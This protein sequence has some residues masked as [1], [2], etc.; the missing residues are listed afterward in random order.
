MTIAAEWAFKRIVRHIFHYKSWQCCKEG[1]LGF[2]CPSISKNG[3]TDGKVFT[4]T[5]S[6]KPIL[7]NIV[8]GSIHSSSLEF[9]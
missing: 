5:Y 6:V 1:R 3:G 4:N 2:R 7:C 8:F 9:F